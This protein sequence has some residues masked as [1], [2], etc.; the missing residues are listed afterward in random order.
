MSIS[1][2]SNPLDILTYLE[3]NIEYGWIGK[4]GKKRINEMKDFR[5]Y[6]QILS[7]EDTI[8]N[9][10]GTC[11]EQVGLIKYFLDKLN[12]KSKMFCTRVYED[13][14]FNKMNEPERMHCFILFYLNNY[15]Y[16]IEHPNPDEK[17][18]YI[19]KDE[20]DAISK[21][22]EIY[23]QMTKNEYKRK[24]IKRKGNI[25][26]LTEFFEIKPGLTFKEFNI[27]INSLDKRK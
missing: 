23:E 5:K 18:I 4:D 2:V 20:A 14:T 17:G 13:E 15:V 6:Y 22:S 3:K 10:V 21:I 19:Y 25:R 16:Q 1:D 24:K 8:K 9:K 11:I 27:Y 12:I 7:V 26:T